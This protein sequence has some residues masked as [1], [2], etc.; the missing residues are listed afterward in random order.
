MRLSV[1]AKIV[2]TTA[3]AG[4]CLGAGL[5]A[6]SGCKTEEHRRTIKGEGGTAAE[7]GG[8]CV[9][10]PGK[11]PTPNCDNSTND[12]RD[13]P[14]C[15]I[16]EGKCGSKG[17][18]LPLTSNKGKSVYD[19]RMRRLTVATPE[20]LTQDFIQAA[21]VTNAIDLKAQECGEIGK[22]TFS[23]LMRV[24]KA[25][26]KLITGGAPPEPDPFGKGFC[27]YNQKV[28]GIDV[29]P[30]TADIEVKDSADGKSFT[31]STVNPQGKLNVPIFLDEAGTAVV[32][33]P[34]TKPRVAN[35]TVNDS[36]CI[37]T[38][39]PIALEGSKCESTPNVCPKWYTAG[40][41]G[42]FI[43]IEEADAVDIKEINAS[44]CV[45]LTKS[46]KD[47][48]TNKCKREGGKIPFKGDYCST[49]DK[50]GD[51]Q[52]S[53]WLAASFAASAAKIQ[54]NPTDNRC[55]GIPS[56]VDAGPDAADAGVDAPA[57]ATTD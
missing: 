39:N 15:T 8:P 9:A 46:P 40:A 41:L 17:T 57:D 3:L 38:F 45:L 37:G 4:V 42:G 34:L 55:R 43:T 18:C 33:L 2:A 35:V 10:E 5:F 19:F 22:G 1:V 20:A 24:D 49:S 54:D 36:D 13:V 23:W 12:C 32:I 25:N 7:D 27:F 16:D 56:V 21:I 44:L 28:N 48:A 14:G 31:W 47:P 52:D 11:L 26:K 50:A 53:F 6:Q 51:C 29:A 30:V